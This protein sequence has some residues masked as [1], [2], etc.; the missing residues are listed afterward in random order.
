MINSGTFPL[1]ASKQKQKKGKKKG[2]EEII[3]AIIEEDEE[4]SSTVTS[5]GED[6]PT[7]GEDSGGEDSDSLEVSV[8]SGD[9]ESYTSSEAEETSEEPDA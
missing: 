7:D 9:E 1:D 4:S 6:E 3:S 2:E 8:S 5:P